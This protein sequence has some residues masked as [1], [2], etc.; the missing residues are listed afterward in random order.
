MSDN[1]IVYN[2]ERLCAFS[3]STLFNKIIRKP[4]RFL[5]GR[6]LKMFAHLTKYGIKCQI[7]TFWGENMVVIIPEVVSMQL[8]YYGFFEEGL[9]KMILE[10]LKEGMIFY[11]IG[12]HFGYF[13]LLGSFCVKEQGE[14]HSFEPTPSTFNIL[15]IN[16]NRKKNVKLNNL[17][18]F[19]KKGEV[20]INDFGFKFSAYNSIYDARLHK[21]TISKINPARHKIETISIDE[22]VENRGAKP[23]FVKIDAESAE[24]EILLGMEKTI[25]KYH[26]IIT[27]EVGDYDVKGIP[28]SRELITYLLSKGYKPFEYSGGKIRPHN[29][30]EY[31]QYDNIMFLPEK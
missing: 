6:I 26:P 3:K 27:I 10:Y 17:A 21:D 13:T 1:N 31:Y 8:Y 7:K 5:S 28:K 18:V 25:E 23:D 30:K 2:L 4:Y 16:V 19:S 24:Y 20:F 9:T 29:I 14:V 12:A 11:D 15:N 22:Y